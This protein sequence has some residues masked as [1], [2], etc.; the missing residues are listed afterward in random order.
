MFYVACS[1]NMF[2]LFLQFLIPS[3]C[4]YSG[5]RYLGPKCVRLAPNGA[6]FNTGIFLRSDSVHFDSD[7]APKRDKFGEPKCT[8][9]DV[10]KVPAR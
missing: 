2:Y 7:W 4:L 9:S 3:V 10:K 5:V 6:N 1:S 8:E